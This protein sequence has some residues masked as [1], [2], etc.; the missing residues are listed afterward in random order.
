MSR[1]SEM[2]NKELIEN[3]PYLTKAE[4]AFLLE[5]NDKNLDKKIS[6]LMKDDIIIPIKNGLYV[7]K[8]FYFKNRENIEEYL[9]NIIYYPSYLSTEYV[10]AKENII[11]EAVFSYTS[12][13]LKTTR[14]FNNSLGNFVYKKIK[15]LIFTGYYQK[16]YFDKY[17][18]KIAKKSKALFDLLYLKPINSLDEIDDLRI[19][20]ENI[21][22]LEIDEFFEYVK[23]SKS[24][25]MARIY[26]FIKKKYDNR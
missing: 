10:L 3:K 16:N 5:K 19:N 2:K 8:I 15:E 6:K 20:W 4:M 9:A 25:K 23:L 7:S 12:V 26:S 13:A 14:E 1:N 11:P 17:T 22:E 18:I 21:N 24:K